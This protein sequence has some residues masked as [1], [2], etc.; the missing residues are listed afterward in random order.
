MVL[1]WASLLG[2]NSTKIF[3]Y[4]F[5]SEHCEWKLVC[6]LSSMCGIF[7]W[8]EWSSGNRMF[9]NNQWTAG[10]YLLSYSELSPCLHSKGYFWPVFSCELLLM[11]ATRVVRAAI[12]ACYS[13]FHLEDKAIRL[14]LMMHL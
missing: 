11:F 7:I 13:F 14:P 9:L 6:N 5:S 10:Q 4:S 12:C 3:A 2:L 1:L 8:L